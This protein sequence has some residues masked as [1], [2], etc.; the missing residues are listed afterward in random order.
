MFGFELVG[1]TGAIATLL[2]IGGMFVLFI[3]EVQPPE[4]IAI[5]TAAVMMLL[6]TLAIFLPLVLVTA[7][8]VRRRAEAAG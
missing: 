3:R 2:I 1:Q 8:Q 5:G 6:I 4:V 7:W